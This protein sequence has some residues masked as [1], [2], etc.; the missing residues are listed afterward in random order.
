MFWKFLAALAAVA[1]TYYGFK[2]N[3]AA[4]AYFWVLYLVYTQNYHHSD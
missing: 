3:Y 1:G 2:E 4:G